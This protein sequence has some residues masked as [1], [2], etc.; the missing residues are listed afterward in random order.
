ILEQWIREHPNAFPV[1]VLHLTDGESTDG[2]PTP[3]GKKITDLHTSDGAVLL[4][5][6]HV[7]STR[8]A[9]VEYPSQDNGLPDNFG[10]TLFAMSSTLPEPFRR[11]ATQIGIHVDEGARGFVFNGDAASVAQFFDIGTRPANLR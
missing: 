11:A 6:C 4:Y 8:G 9:K 10:K 5:T 2:D 3:I 1:T 7:S